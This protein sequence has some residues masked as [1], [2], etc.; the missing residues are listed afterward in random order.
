MPRASASNVV[1]S[2]LVAQKF[3]T[4]K[5]FTTPFLVLWLQSWNDN[6]V[7][8]NEKM[9]FITVLIW[10]KLLLDPPF[11]AKYYSKPSWFPRYTH[12]YFRWSLTNPITVCGLTIHSSESNWFPFCKLNYSFSLIQI[13][14][15]FERV[16]CIIAAISM[17]S[18]I[19]NEKSD[20]QVNGF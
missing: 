17:C 6:Q 5:K 2:R 1:R 18:W 12:Y 15:R 9:K 7:L 14:F 20:K 11:S 4:T 19:E 13:L 10:I 16:Y 8:E 3:T